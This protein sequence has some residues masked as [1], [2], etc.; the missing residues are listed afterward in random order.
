MRFTVEAGGVRARRRRVRDAAPAGRRTR[1]RST[2]RS[3]SSSTSGAAR[4][5]RG[6]CCAAR[7]RP[8]RGRSRSSGEPEDDVAAALAELDAPLEAAPAPDIVGAGTRPPRRR[9]RRD[10]RRARRVGRA[11]ARRR[12][13]THARAGATSPGGSAASRCARGPR[14][15]ATRARGRLR[16]RRR[17]R[18]ARDRGGAPRSP[19]AHGRDGPSRLGRGRGALRARGPRAHVRAPRA[20]GRALP[21]AARRRRLGAALAATG[22]PAVAGRALRVLVELGLVAVD[23][24]TLAVAVPA[25]LRTDLE[26]SPAFRPRPRACAPGARSSAS[27]SRAPP[28]HS[29]STSA[30]RRGVRLGGGRGYP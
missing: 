27:A 11:G 30:A 29:G 20:G 3:G 9:R 2:R 17:A 23:R 8:S 15:S 10:D 19:A 6:W 18:P 22:P 25:G 4:S 26:R 13:P 7:S 16:P 1:A 24:A 28:R 5:S 21:R 12:A 14:S